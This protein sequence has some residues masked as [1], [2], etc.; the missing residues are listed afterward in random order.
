[1]IDVMGKEVCEFPNMTFVDGY[2]EAYIDQMNCSDT[3]AF[4][5]PV[6]VGDD[7]VGLTEY[8]NTRVRRQWVCNNKEL[9][10]DGSDEWCHVISD[11]CTVHKHQLCDGHAD[12]EGAPDESKTI[13]HNVSRKTC[14]R[15]YVR[16]EMEEMALPVTW[17]CDGQE[18][19][20]NGMDERSSEWRVCGSGEES[21][22]Y[23]N[24]PEYDCSQVCNAD[25]YPINHQVPC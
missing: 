5:C 21:V 22:C 9:C 13:C 16:S 18:D 4:V 12:C 6:R 2:C 25:N 20:L 7:E 17:L 19:C 1:M 10:A 14:Q 15:R 3:N 11:R 8:P 23:P 24:T